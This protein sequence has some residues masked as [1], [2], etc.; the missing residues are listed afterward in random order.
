MKSNIL[1]IYEGGCSVSDA[2]Y[3]GYFT[4]NAEYLFSLFWGGWTYFLS[5]C[6]KEDLQEMKLDQKPQELSFITM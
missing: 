4:T 3:K 6:P 2:S 1:Q 5:K